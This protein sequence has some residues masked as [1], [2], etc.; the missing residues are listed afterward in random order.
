M[1]DGIRVEHIKLPLL[2]E[3]LYIMYGGNMQTFR[4]KSR[5]PPNLSR[6]LWLRNYLV[7][8]AKRN[9]WKNLPKNQGTKNY[10]SRSLVVVCLFLRYFMLSSEFLSPSKINWMRLFGINM[11]LHKNYLTISNRIPM[12]HCHTI[13]LL[14]DLRVASHIHSKNYGVKIRPQKGHFWPH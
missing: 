9:I 10:T 11:L 12:Y 6:M 2:F 14:V 5:N 13:F 3:Y 4:P 1:I 7:C 8:A